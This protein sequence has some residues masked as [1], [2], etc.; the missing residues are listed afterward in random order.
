MSENEEALKT[1]LNEH[2]LRVKRITDFLK[3]S[4]GMSALLIGEHE[5]ILASTLEEAF[6]CSVIWFEPMENFNGART[7][8]M[9]DTVAIKRPK[10]NPH[11]MP[12]DSECFDR[13]ASQFTLN[14]LRDPI[15]ALTDWCRVLKKDGIAAFVLSTAHLLDGTKD[16]CRE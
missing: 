16:P 3:L 4:G 9:A 2:R 1:S 8:D 14:Y 12:F 15:S 11:R 10:G 5:G 6:G 13:L 7:S